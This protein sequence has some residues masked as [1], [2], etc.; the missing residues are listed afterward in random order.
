MFRRSLQ[1]KML[2]SNVDKGKSLLF[3]L[4]PSNKRLYK[5]S[6]RSLTIIISLILALLVSTIDVFFEASWQHFVVIFGVV[7][8]AASFLLYYVVD[9]Y[10]RN[11]IKL[12][13]KIIHQ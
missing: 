1:Q 5:L 9:I 12:V 8:I 2:S 7:F 11:R 3:R 4:A 13:Y 10:L 6:A